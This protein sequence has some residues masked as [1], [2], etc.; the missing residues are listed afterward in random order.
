MRRAA[1]NSPLRARGSGTGAVRICQS[2]AGIS[3]ETRGTG[4]QPVLS[5]VW[6]RMAWK[7][8][9]TSGCKARVNTW[10]TLRHGSK[11]CSDTETYWLL[12]LSLLLPRAG[13]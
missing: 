7:A 3:V 11:P 2:G 13:K 9:A 5:S 12:A 4:F 6:S 8:N 10:R 1:W